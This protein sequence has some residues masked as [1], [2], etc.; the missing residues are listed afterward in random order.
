MNHPFATLLA[1]V[2]GALS[3]AAVADQMTGNLITYDNANDAFTVDGGPGGSSP[4][5]GVPAG[6]I[7]AV[8]SPRTS[9]SVPGSPVAP[10]PAQLRQSTTMGGEKK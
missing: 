4:A 10:P 5:P 8:L 6:R 7:R 9:A 3:G 1:C 2:F